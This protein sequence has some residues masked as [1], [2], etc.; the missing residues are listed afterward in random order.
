MFAQPTW[1]KLS[2][3]PHECPPQGNMGAYCLPTNIVASL[4]PDGPDSNLG[5]PPSRNS[6]SMIQAIL[7]QR[8]TA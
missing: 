3:H 7:T 2:H 4:Y 8:R 5:T 1:R 6:R